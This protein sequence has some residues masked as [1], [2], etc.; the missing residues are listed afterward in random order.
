MIQSQFYG[1]DFKTQ[2]QSNE[3][4]F[5]VEKIENPPEQ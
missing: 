1:S 3:P 5:V 4:L 2:M